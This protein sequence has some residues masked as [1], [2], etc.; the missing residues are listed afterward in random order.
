M[1]LR[2]YRRGSGDVALGIGAV[3]ADTPAVFPAKG[4]SRLTIVGRA[5]A[6]NWTLDVYLGLK[7]SGT[8]AL[9]AT[10]ICTV[11]VPLNISL[12]IGGE[13][14]GLV[15]TNGAVAQ[16]PEVLVTLEEDS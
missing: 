5:P 16:S 8:T 2:A 10:F 12:A 14:G 11:A 3:A 4:F 15:L 7:A 9:V 13:I 1:P 6:G